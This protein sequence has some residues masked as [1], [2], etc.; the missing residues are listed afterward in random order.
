MEE[1]EVVK[2]WRRVKKEVDTI[3]HGCRE[4]RNENAEPPESKNK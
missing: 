1:R 2:R 3:I 4:E